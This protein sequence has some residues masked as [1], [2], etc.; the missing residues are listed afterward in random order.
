MGRQCMERETDMSIIINL[1]SKFGMFTPAAEISEEA[2]DARLNRIQ[3]REAR[4]NVRSPIF[5]RGQA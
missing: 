2:F 3:T 1:L 5:V 4:R